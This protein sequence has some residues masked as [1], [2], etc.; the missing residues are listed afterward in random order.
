MLD[1][2]QGVGI[3]I[4]FFDEIQAVSPALL[5]GGKQRNGTKADL[6]HCFES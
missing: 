2:K 5:C 1:V 4:N 6:L 3:W